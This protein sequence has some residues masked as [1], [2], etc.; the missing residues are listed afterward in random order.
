M[1]YEVF[2]TLLNCPLPAVPALLTPTLPD[3]AGL[4][5][6][7]IINYKLTRKE[8]RKSCDYKGDD[9]HLKLP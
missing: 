6:S 5:A 8:G 3:K 4:L 2:A 7:V 1:V 9:F